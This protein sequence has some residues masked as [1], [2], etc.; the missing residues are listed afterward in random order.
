MHAKD[1]STLNFSDINFSA[2]RNAKAVHMYST[3]L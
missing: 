1:M 3:D 2:E